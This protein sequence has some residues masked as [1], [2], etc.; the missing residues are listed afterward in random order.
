MLQLIM[1]IIKQWQYMIQRAK[2]LDRKDLMAIIRSTAQV[3]HRCKE[4]Y[5]CACITVLETTK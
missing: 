3:N 5:G 2:L 4:C 1:A